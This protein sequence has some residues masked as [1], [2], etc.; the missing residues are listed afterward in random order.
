MIIKKAIT[1][2]PFELGKLSNELADKFALSWPDYSE[3]E[4]DFY[5]MSLKDRMEYLKPH[6]DKHIKESP[7]LK[8]HVPFL[9]KNKD[10]LLKLVAK[11]LKTGMDCF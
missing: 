7:Q 8:K 9:T 1:K 3:D 5:R 6:V 4:G 10:K 2:K 11:D